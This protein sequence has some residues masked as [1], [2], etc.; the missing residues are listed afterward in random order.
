MKFKVLFYDE[1]RKWLKEDLELSD[2]TVNSYSDNYLPGLFKRLKSK[3]LNGSSLMSS[4]LPSML[5]NDPWKAITELYKLLQLWKSKDQ[6]VFAG[7]KGLAQSTV[8]NYASALAR[9]IDF[10][11]DIIL[12]GR[13][14]TLLGK[15]PTTHVTSISLPGIPILSYSRDDLVGVFK[16]RL[17]T[18]D[19][20]PI[21][22]VYFPIRLIK[23]I[24]SSASGG[25]NWLS[26]WLTRYARGIRILGKKEIYRVGE[27]DSLDIHG[28]AV[29]VNVKSDRVLTETT[30]IRRPNP[31][32]MQAI[33]LADISINHDVPIS[34]MLAAGN[35][36]ALDVIKKMVDSWYRVNRPNA[37]SIKQGDANAIAQGVFADFL[38]LPPAQKKKLIDGLKKDLERIAI[39]PLTLM[40]RGENSR[41][42]NRF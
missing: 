21:A 16:A 38:K 39:S 12:T 33:T 29:Y 36:H 8:D 32:L 13:L 6:T 25:R 2:G 30:S 26:V 41:K 37:H 9:Y 4:V 1:W 23:K 15:V 7:I 42:N 10:L 31:D 17:R 20:F 40:E 27:I 14:T 22:G 19:R 11:V 5:A 18:Q 24:I 34:I 35:W 28:K 3:G